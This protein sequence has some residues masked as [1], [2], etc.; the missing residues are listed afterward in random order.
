MEGEGFSV[1]DGSSLCSLTNSP[2]VAADYWNSLDPWRGGSLNLDCRDRAGEPW[3]SRRSYKHLEHSWR[4]LFVDRLDF[5]QTF[6]AFSFYQ[7]TSEKGEAYTAFS[8]RHRKFPNFR[9]SCCQ[10]CNWARHVD[11]GLW[12]LCWS[13][14]PFSPLPFPALPYPQGD[15]LWK[16]STSLQYLTLGGGERHSHPLYKDRLRAYLCHF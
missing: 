5:T 12:D 9:F 10:L 4:F 15:K 13:P 14:F 3:L 1:C 16:V 7:I 11:A 2:P 8:P 6:S